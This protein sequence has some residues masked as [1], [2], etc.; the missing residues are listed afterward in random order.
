MRALDEI[1]DKGLNLATELAGIT[2]LP[3]TKDVVDQI[4][5][6]SEKAL[7]I[8]TKLITPR[9]FRNM[10]LGQLTEENLRYMVTGD[11]ATKSHNVVVPLKHQD[12]G[13]LGAMLFDLEGFQVGPEEE[14]KIGLLMEYVGKSAGQMIVASK[15]LQEE[16]I[17]A[18]FDKHTGLMNK[19]YFLTEVMPRVTQYSEENPDAPISFL[20]F[21]LNRFKGVND[22]F[23]H[24]HGDSVL[25]EIGEIVNRNIYRTTDVATI[26]QRKHPSKP[27]GGDTEEAVRYGGEEFVVVL[28]GTD[29]K[30]ARIVADRMY[31]AI[32]DHTFSTESARDKG[33]SVYYPYGPSHVTTSIG[34][35]TY[36]GK[37]VSAESLLDK[38]DDMLY[39]AKDLQRDKEKALERD[40]KVAYESL[41][42]PIVSL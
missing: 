19:S 6:R 27:L 28:F 11:V 32:A 1:V 23:G 9:E 8:P 29:A 20:M 2:I 13:N 18:R 35:A 24:L 12:Y 21:D 40:G 26:Y 30:G 5:N 10:D 41:G 16:T 34:V 36:P 22:R 39:Q 25:T 7:G 17:K 31:D 3:N 37:I 14:S 15:N 38:A 42:R 33:S 4:S